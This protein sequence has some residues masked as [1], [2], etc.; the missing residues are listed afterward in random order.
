MSF[1]ELQ[2]FLE[3]AFKLLEEREFNVDRQ[4]WTKFYQ[5]HN[6]TPE[7]LKAAKLEILSKIKNIENDFAQQK[8]LEQLFSCDPFDVQNIKALQDS[9]HNRAESEPEPFEKWFA[10]ISIHLLEVDTEISSPSLQSTILDISKDNQP[11]QEIT[12]TTTKI[13][14]NTSVKDSNPLL[15]AVIIGSI[16]GLFIMLALIINNYVNR[17]QQLSPKPESQPMENANNQPEGSKEENNNHNIFDQESFPR[18]S[19]GDPMPYNLAEFPVTYYPIYTDYSAEN[20]QIIKNNF[21]RDAY[22][23]T[24]KNTGKFSIQVAS[25][26]DYQK[27]EQFRDFLIRE[28]GSG[29]MGEGRTFD[30]PPQ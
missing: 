20:L 29:E 3:E 19:C 8:A 10:D 4:T 12:N 6:I 22:K 5:E 21:C 24:R 26:R 25:F 14:H 30:R 27:A 1:Q 16:I 9:W 18:S 11:T 28:V 23:M 7:Q 15:P 17:Q 13:D 2:P